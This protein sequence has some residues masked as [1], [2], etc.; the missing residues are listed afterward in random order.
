VHHAQQDHQALT[1]SG[2][3]E[4]HSFAVFSLVNG[5]YTLSPIGGPLPS[6]SGVY[7]FV[8]G[9]AIKYIGSAANFRG[10]MRD[11]LRWQ[12]NGGG[13]TQRPIHLHLRQ[14]LSQEPVTVIFRHFKDDE[15]GDWQGLPVNLLLGVEA[16]LIGKL[17][18]SWNRRG[19]KMMSLEL[20]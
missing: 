15:L 11:Y 19:I 5:Q 9:K 14:A 12:Q 2:L 10:R 6:A 18:P 17:S 20:P 4:F 16:G 3:P 8:Q 1:I 13:R 7:A